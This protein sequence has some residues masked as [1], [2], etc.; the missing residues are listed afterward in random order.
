[1]KNSKKKRRGFCVFKIIKTLKFI[2]IFIFIFLNSCSS[3]GEKPEIIEIKD[4]LF[5]F[6][7]DLGFLALNSLKASTDWSGKETNLAREEVVRFQKKVWEKYR[8]EYEILNN[9]KWIYP[10]QI[11]DSK[12]AILEDFSKNV[13][14]LPE[15]RPILKRT[16]EFFENVETEWRTNFPKSSGLMKEITRLRFEK[17]FT[18]YITHPFLNQG[19]SLGRNSIAIGGSMINNSYYFPNNSIVYIWHEVLHYYLGKSQKSHAL[20]ELATDNELRARL[21]RT[22]NDFSI[23]HDKL[24]VLREKLAPRWKDYLKNKSENL[25]SLEKSILEEEDN[26]NCCK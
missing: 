3:F 12:L 11:G 9:F 4:G 1:M 26:L 18:V 6:K 19:K 17:S 24:K 22:T 2:F 14:A 20:I 21:N 16:Q 23:G 13:V 25:I 8:E 7:L 10:W 5:L 15:F